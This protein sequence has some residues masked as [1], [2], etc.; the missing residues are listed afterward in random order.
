MRRRRWTPHYSED[1][2]ATA[3]TG[4]DEL[5]YYMIRR[6]DPPGGIGEYV[7]RRG[8]GY[9]ISKPTHL[10]EL[11]LRAEVIGRYWSAPGAKAAARRHLRNNS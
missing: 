9:L 11:T 8:A 1:D 5:A 4:L 7:T 6:I 10:W 2:T 3:Y